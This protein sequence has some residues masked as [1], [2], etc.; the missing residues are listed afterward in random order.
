MISLTYY[1]ILTRLSKRKHKVPWQHIRVID[2]T[3]LAENCALALHF[4]HIVIEVDGL[5]RTVY[6]A[7]ANI[8]D[9]GSFKE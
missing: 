9:R 2:G 8:G 5:S 3:L 6:S 7:V 1:N 4:T